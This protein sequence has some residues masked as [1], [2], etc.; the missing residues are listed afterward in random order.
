MHKCEHC[1][2]NLNE[3]GV[4][5]DSHCYQVHTA[6]GW[7]DVDYGGVIEYYCPECGGEIATEVALDVEDGW[8]GEDKWHSSK[9]ERR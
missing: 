8:N 7:G 9:A 5:Y 1:G 4:G 3:C 6:E 2:A